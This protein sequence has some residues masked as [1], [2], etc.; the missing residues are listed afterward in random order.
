MKRAVAGC[1]MV[2]LAAALNLLLTSVARADC[3]EE[4]RAMRG[5]LA[6]V[7]DESRRQELQRL[8]EKAEKDERAGRDQLCDQAVQRAHLL[9]K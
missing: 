3:A 1:G 8:L 5:M 6:D 4:L 2:L 9:L 7:K